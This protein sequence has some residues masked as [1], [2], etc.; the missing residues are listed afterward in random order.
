LQV[1]ARKPV[2][3]APAL[4]GVA[5]PDGAGAALDAALNW[6]AAS[7]PSMETGAPAPDAAADELHLQLNPILA[8]ERHVMLKMLEHHRWNVSNVA[9][10]FDVSRN[11]LYRRLHKLH[12]RISHPE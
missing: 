2:P 5:R 9:K 12:I 1:A 7:L 3:P 4:L 8:N 10:A 11:T 6:P